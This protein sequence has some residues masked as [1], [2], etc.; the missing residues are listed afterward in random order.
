VKA[1]S[2]VVST[3]KGPEHTGKGS[4]GEVDVTRWVL[5]RCR[6]AGAIPVVQGDLGSLTF[7]RQQYDN[8]ESTWD[9]MQRAAKTV[10]AWC[11]EFEQILTFGRPTFLASRSRARWWEIYWN[12]YGNYT[13][14]LAG[15]PSYSWSLDGGSEAMTFDLV[16]IDGDLARPGD[17]ATLSGNVG[18]AAGDWIVTDVGIPLSMNSPVRVTCARIV[19]PAPQAANNS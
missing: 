6:E 13:P 3:L 7:T 16:S 9:V 17:G 4:W 15:M 10:G 14:G 11:Y 19:D 12:S 5:E 8:E 18:S 1:R 2:R